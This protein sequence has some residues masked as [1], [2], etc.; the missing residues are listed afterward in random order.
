MPIPTAT[1]ACGDLE[2]K[3][4]MP[5]MPLDDGAR[6]YYPAGREAGET[7][8]C[9]VF[10]GAAA[11]YYLSL[12]FCRRAVRGCREGHPHPPPPRRAAVGPLSIRGGSPAAARTVFLNLFPGKEL[13]PRKWK[14]SDWSGL[15]PARSAPPLRAAPRHG[16]TALVVCLGQGCLAAGQ[17]G[18]GLTWPPARRPALPRG[19][20][21]KAGRWA[22]GV[23]PGRR[24]TCCPPVRGSEQSGAPA[25][26]R[27][28][29][30][31]LHRGDE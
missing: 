14:Q 30:L 31:R 8:N 12:F 19:P 21:G 29:E 10:S 26:Q 27:D 18:V 4:L 11:A 20:R 13:L 25:R 7:T 17:A 9:S 24:R 3:Q 5:P 1:V 23:R 16:G 15:A 28:R 2:I 6:V 22:G